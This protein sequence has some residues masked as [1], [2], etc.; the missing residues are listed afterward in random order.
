MA[1]DK[2]ATIYRL[3]VEDIYLVAESDE[4]LD[5]LIDD[6]V[7]RVARKVEAMDFSDLSETIGEFISDAIEDKKKEEQ[8][9]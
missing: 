6:I 2:D 8:D 7:S 4:R 1:L 5:D 9:R 3:T